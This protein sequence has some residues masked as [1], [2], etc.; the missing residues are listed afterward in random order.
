MKRR[1]LMVS[2]M[3]LIFGSQ[4]H[5]EAHKKGEPAPKRPGM[6]MHRPPVV[7]FDG[8]GPA[9]DKFDA[10]RPGRPI[11][12]AICQGEIE[13]I[14]NYYWKRYGIRLSKREAEKILI[15]DMRHRPHFPRPRR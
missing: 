13:R 7:K 11:G 3:I 9:M 8:R 5:M 15:A 10:R 2:A 14:Q 12:K 4:I 1:F 6:E